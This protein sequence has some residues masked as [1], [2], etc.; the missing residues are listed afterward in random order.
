MDR[1]RRKV[2]HDCEHAGRLVKRF[3]LVGFPQTTAPRYTSGEG[4]CMGTNAD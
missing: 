3:L 1:C 2:A 4:R